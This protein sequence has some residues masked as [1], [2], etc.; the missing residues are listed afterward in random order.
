MKDGPTFGSVFTGIGG[1]DLG[2]ERAGWKAAWQIE[3]D[4]Y[5]RGV[6]EA[7]WP[8]VRRYGDIRH[9]DPAL[10]ERPGLVCAGFP[11][12][13]VS[14]ASGAG[15]GRLRLDGAKSG[16]WA[17]LM[18]LVRHLRPGYVLVENSTSLLVRGLDRMVG[19]L[20]Q[21]GYDAEWDCLPAAAFG[22]P[23]IRD[24]LYLLAY[25]GE[26]RHGAPDETVF[27][28]W[29]QSQLHAGWAR[30]PEICGVADGVPRRVDRLRA[31]G[32]ALVPPA[33]EWLGRR[34]LRTL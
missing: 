34:I 9:V 24:R 21:S 30:R 16:L 14:R 1:F 28:G 15:N 5:R 13:D 20:A 12:E 27:A 19:D 8:Y 18:R 22:A 31:L 17:E 26:R 4:P 6:L 10:L 33:A 32:D 2:L 11:C 29:A 7:H 3:V 23:H 25:P